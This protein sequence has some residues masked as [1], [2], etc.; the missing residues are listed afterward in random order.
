MMRVTVFFKGNSTS[1]H[2][3]R[4]SPSS[5]TRTHQ[6]TSFRGRRVRAVVPLDRRPITSVR[7]LFPGPSPSAQLFPLHPPLCLRQTFSR[8]QLSPQSFPLRSADHAFASHYR[9]PSYLGRAVPF[10]FSLWAAWTG[11]LPLIC[12]LLQVADAVLARFAETWGQLAF[13]CFSTNQRSPSS[14]KSNS[15]SSRWT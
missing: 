11:K 10:L 7:P 15:S 4:T 9:A 13:M 2:P 3:S 1:A 12:V 14:P 5:S 6:P 8:G